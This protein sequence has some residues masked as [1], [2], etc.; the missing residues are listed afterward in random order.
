MPGKRD[1]TLLFGV[2]LLSAMGVTLILP[3]MPAMA[4]TFGLSIA[5]AGMVVVCFTLAEA[6]MTPVA[7]V[8]SDRFGRMAVLLPALLVFAGGG[9]LCL[10]AESWRDVLICRVIQGI[11]AGPL[12]VLYTI[13]A[14]DMVDEKHLPRIMGRLT[15]VSSLGTIVYPVIGG[16]LG[17]W[18]WRAPFFVFTLALPTAVLSLM[19]TLEKPQG[20]MDWR[21]YWK[22]TGNI[23][24][25]RRAIGFFVLVFLCYCAIYGPINTCFPMMAE[26]KYHASSSRIGLV[27]SFVAIGSYLAAA[28]LPRLHAKWSFRTL[29]LVAG[30]CYTLPLAFL[31]SVPGL[32]LC[33][34]P[35]F[36][37]GAA[38]GLSLPIIND[39]VALLGTPDDRA[40]ILAVSETSVRVSQSVSPLLFS[41]ISMKWLWDG[42][43]ASGFAVGIL[44]LLV[45][46][47]CVRTPYRSIAEIKKRLPS[48]SQ[49]KQKGRE[50]LPGPFVCKEN[51]PLTSIFSKFKISV[52]AAS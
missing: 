47:F 5:E 52:C 2:R 7:G 25:E 51:F 45:A 44:I 9:I 39:N 29:I 24:R 19:V 21:R 4:R 49:D 37:S 23:L 36:V 32:W 26:A 17:E 31:A 13:L 28:G 30:F 43:Y 18:S 33:A 34:V 3:V 46:F 20:A 11:G 42:A 38:Q 40:A 50:M 35:L 22:Q 27:F 16:L 48:S 14:A 10:F 15:A 41:I 1:L 8:L 12:G 6:T